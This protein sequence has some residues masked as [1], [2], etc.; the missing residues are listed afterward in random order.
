MSL[1]FF[2]Q[3]SHDEKK[4]RKNSIC[5]LHFKIG[6]H[7]SCGLILIEIAERDTPYLLITSLL[8][9]SGVASSNV[10]RLEII[11]KNISINLELSV[12][13]HLSH[14]SLVFFSFASVSNSL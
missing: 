5:S 8:V 9:I 7:T 13:H 2:N 6:L 10:P 4:K 11:N 14:C 1:I 3:N 12:H